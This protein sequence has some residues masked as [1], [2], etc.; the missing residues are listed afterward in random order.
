[1]FIDMGY[2]AY[3]AITVSPH[4]LPDFA[5]LFLAYLFAPGPITLLST[6]P[7]PSPKK[8]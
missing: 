3:T 7:Q 4:H 8:T 6:P 2:M 5:L 1:M